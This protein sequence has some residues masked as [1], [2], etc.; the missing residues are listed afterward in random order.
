MLTVQG[1][2]SPPMCP[3]NSS[4]GGGGGRSSIDTRVV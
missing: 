4:G 1:A 2:Y 3:L